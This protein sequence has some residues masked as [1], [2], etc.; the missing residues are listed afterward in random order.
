MWAGT[1]I[2]YQLLLFILTPESKFQSLVIIIACAGVGT[3]IY[4]YLGLKSGLVNR[5]FGDRVDQIKRK[6][7]LTN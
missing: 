6:L 1:E 3:V 7:R 2:V 4:F 5:L